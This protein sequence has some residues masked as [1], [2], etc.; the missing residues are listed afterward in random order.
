MKN[1]TVYILIAAAALLLLSSTGGAAGLPAGL[2]AL[3]NEYET[4]NN[5]SRYLTA[6]QDTGGV[7]TI[8]YGSIYNY[9]ANRRVQDGDKIDADTAYKWYTIEAIEK[10]QQVK[11]MVHVPING[12]QLTAL[13]DLAYNIG[14]TALRDSTLMQLLN[15][16]APKQQVADQFDRWIYDNG[17]VQPGLV[18]RR[19]AE[20]ELFLS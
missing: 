13:V 8:G 1:T 9:D 5:V 7:W 11:D 15:S 18:T 2:F 6:Y 12:N 14:D 16:G 4:S 19:A 10:T 3:I 17:K 20:K